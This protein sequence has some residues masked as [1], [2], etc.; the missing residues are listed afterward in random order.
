MTSVANKRAYPRYPVRLDAVAISAQGV[1]LDCVVEDFCQGGLFI[2]FHPQAAHTPHWRIGDYIE[3][4][5]AQ[6]PGSTH[7]DYV[8]QGR[9]AR[10][11]DIGV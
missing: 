11:I 10:V 9:V 8:V 1:R 2:T 4:H 6:A 7:Q 5:L 3:V